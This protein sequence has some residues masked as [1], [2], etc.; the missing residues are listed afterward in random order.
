[1]NR[2]VRHC[3]KTALDEAHMSFEGR[4]CSALSH[5]IL[6]LQT[7]RVQR[8]LLLFQD[9]LRRLS[10]PWNKNPRDSERGDVL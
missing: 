3:I 7:T 1:M 5:P 9:T 4:T 10:Q 6:V 2:F 8:S